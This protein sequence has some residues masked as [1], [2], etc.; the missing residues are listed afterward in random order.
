MTTKTSLQATLRQIVSQASSL[1]ERLEGPYLPAGTPDD[2]EL[3]EKRLDEWTQ[4]LSSD[5]K[6]E[7]LDRLLEWEGLDMTAARRAVGPVQLRE[8]A[9]LPAWAETLAAALSLTLNASEDAPESLASPGLL[10][11]DDP[12]PFEDLLVPFV[13]VFHERMATCPGY[14]VLAEEAWITQARL[15]LSALSS[16]AAQP[17]HLEFQMFRTRGMGPLAQ[18]LSTAAEKPADTLYRQ[19]VQGMRAGGLVTFFQKYAVL[20]RILSTLTHFLAETTVEFLQRLAADRQEIP[21]VFGQG[22][23]LGQ[24]NDLELGLSDPHRG[25]HSVIGLSFE[26]GL[27][28]I[29][30]P[31]DL[32]TEAAYNQLLT[33]LNEQEGAPLDL[34][35]LQVLNRGTHGWVEF[36]ESQPCADEAEVSRYYRRAGMLLGLVYALEGTDCHAENLM[37]SGEYPVLI[38]N[39]TLLHHRVSPGESEEW[40]ASARF[41]AD[42]QLLHSILRVGM[43]PLWSFGKDESVAYDMSGLGGYADQPLPFRGLHWLHTNTDL[44]APEYRTGK[45]PARSNIPHLDDTPA[46]LNEHVEEIGEGFRQ[47]YRFLLTH[48]RPLMAPGG[49]LDAFKG[50]QVRFVFRATQVYGLLQKQVRQP[51]YLRDGADWS[52]PLEMLARVYLLADEKPA[53]WPILRSERRSMQQ[54]DVPFFTARVDS[55]ALVLGPEEELE[56]YFTGPSFDLVVERLKSLDEADL[57]LQ[58]QLIRSSLHARVADHVHE[59]VSVED[60]DAEPEIMPPLQEDALVAAAVSLAEELQVR[61]IRGTDGSATWIALQYVPRAERFQLGQL[62]QDLYSGLPG[63]A[64][65]LAALEKASGGVG[66]FGDLSLAALQPTREALQGAKTDPGTIRWMD[67][68]GASGMGSLLYALV[69]T[70]QFLGEPA[71]VAEA[72][73]VVTVMT[74]DVIAADQT[75]DIIGGSA[76]AILGLL[77]LYEASQ[78]AP[79]T[80]AGSVQATSAGSVQATSAGSVQCLQR[81]V[82]CGRHL[83]ANRVASVAGPRTWLSFGQ[84]LT[85]FGHGAAGIAYALLRLYAATGDTDFRAAAEEAIAY[86]ESVFVEAEG[87]WLDLRPLD[88]RDLE[89][90]DQD[91][92]VAWCA[93]ATGIGLARIGGL[94][95][96]DTPAIRQDIE[97]ALA[98]TQQEL[99]GQRLLSDHPCCGNMGRIE[100][101]LT[102]GLRLSRPELAATA[103]LT[104]SQVVARAGRLGRY[105]FPLPVQEVVYNPTFFQGTAGIGYELL[106]LA[107][108]DQVPSV[109]LWE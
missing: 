9:P 94:P 69:R 8:D 54:L 92:M 35:A 100:L 17:L 75:F 24:V 1:T 102:A 22:E 74:P 105:N 73:V 10:D 80:S 40:H 66:G 96:L 83:L 56:A 55:D 84:P 76:G 88:G 51:R 61:A 63:V 79:V 98:T 60:R 46:R 70:G 82:E 101:L 107:H 86:E 85:G 45:M 14:D 34:K 77:A 30:K 25:G 3:I 21:R 109:L 37:A 42:E 44:M 71:L 90:G 106:R 72:E 4:A 29:Y 108:P 28:L 104:A 65:F 38:D 91:F 32:G 47:M 53:S 64:L 57:N 50:K 15:L 26:D 31:K 19:F 23:D 39:E 48:G 52:I 103:R 89:S 43:L 41:E 78:D 12:V 18:L 49:P 2:G 81:A 5:G 6:R 67:I 97:I 33:W 20:A 11:A 59:T 27:H 95:W 13:L 93:G 16:W 58:A 99:A 87:N 36:V 62:G 68:G 7:D